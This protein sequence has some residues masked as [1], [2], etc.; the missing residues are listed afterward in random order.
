MDA[1]INRVS[2]D[3]VSSSEKFS[4]FRKYR[5]A[6]NGFAVEMSEATADKVTNLLTK[7]WRT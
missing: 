4:V 7:F 1:V 6:L 2:R 5:A 3:M